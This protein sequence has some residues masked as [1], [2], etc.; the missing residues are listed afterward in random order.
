MDSREAFLRQE[1]ESASPAKL[2]FLLLQ[3]A[4]GLSL[5]VLNL[6]QQNKHDEGD[7]WVIRIQDIVN[8]LLSGVVDPKHDL[9][10]ITSDLYVF[11]SRLVAAVLI[12]RDA[13]ALHNV[14]EILEIEMET[15][16]MYV[17]K[18]TLDRASA[19]GHAGTSSE[20][21]TGFF[22]INA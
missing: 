13:E 1:V 7:Q 15:W 20:E 21:A 3:K 5:V 10:Q 11:L 12:E 4:H 6:W 8:E 22:S 2:R 19:A 18:E 16:Q 14:S 9:A 17:R